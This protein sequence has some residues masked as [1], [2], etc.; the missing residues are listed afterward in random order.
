MWSV[1]L[2]ALPGLFLCAAR[3]AGV[4]LAA[5]WFSQNNI[6]TQVRVALVL[7]IA[8]SLWSAMGSGSWSGADPLVVMLVM[9]LELL[10]GL[11]LGFAVRLLLAVLEI[12][13]EFMSFQM[14][15]AAAAAFDPTVGGVSSPPTRLFYM[16]ALVVFLAIDGHHHLLLALAYSYDVVPL[17]AAGLHV[18]N[19]EAFLELVA[20]LFHSALQLALPLMVVMLTINLVLGLMVRFLPQLN[21]FTIGFILTIGVGLWLLTELMPSLGLWIETLLTSANDWLPRLLRPPR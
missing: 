18:I 20:G 16:V 5:P 14:G 21:V 19:A 10:V 4:A 12:A 2:A 17:G 7:M 11:T 13:G 15:Y 3:V 6:P 8:A 9:P 1:I